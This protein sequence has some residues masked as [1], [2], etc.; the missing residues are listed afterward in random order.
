MANS[1]SDWSNHEIAAQEGGGFRGRRG[2]E[3]IGGLAPLPRGAAPPR[4]AET[5]ERGAQGRATGPAAPGAAAAR[6]RRKPQAGRKKCRFARAMG[7]DD[8]G[9]CAGGNGRAK[10]TKDRG[11]A[12]LQRDVI[13]NQ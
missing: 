1:C 2:V 13:E 8:G 7:P 6:G 11:G 5:R 4:R 10:T 3:K 12:R 9:R